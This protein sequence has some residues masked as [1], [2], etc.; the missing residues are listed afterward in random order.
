MNTPTHQDYLSVLGK[1]GLDNLHRFFSSWQIP[2]GL[3]DEQIKILSKLYTVKKE[4]IDEYISKR[5]PG[6]SYRES[7]EVMNPPSVPREAYDLLSQ[8]S[9]SDE[10]FKEAIYLFLKQVV[11]Q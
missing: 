2:K 7:H 6:R 5:D 4:F 11:K 10:D 1:T 9:V 8:E 3:T